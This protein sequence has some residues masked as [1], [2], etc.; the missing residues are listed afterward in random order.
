MYTLVTFSD[1]IALEAFILSATEGTIRMAAQGF[2]DVVILNRFGNEWISDG[3]S[4][5]V[6]QF[7]ASAAPECRTWSI[8]RFAVNR[9]S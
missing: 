2:D 9:A 3:G 8:P 4:R 7:I 5:V 6:F 1:A